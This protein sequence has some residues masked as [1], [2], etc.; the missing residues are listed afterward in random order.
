VLDGLSIGFK[1]REQKRGTRQGEPARTLLNIDLWEISLV[2]FP[3]NDKARIS[4]V[5]TLTPDQARELESLLGE[6]GVSREHAVRAVAAFKQWLQS[7]S[8][9]PDT[10][11]REEVAPVDGRSVEDAALAADKL[12]A[13]IVSGLLKY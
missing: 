13:S 12:M 1:V 3:A 5:K 2:T 9:A 11:L 8:E 6:R 4:S 7:E 10:V